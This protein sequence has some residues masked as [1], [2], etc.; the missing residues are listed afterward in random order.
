MLMHMRVGPYCMFTPPPLARYE[1][2]I[3][4]LHL[5]DLAVPLSNLPYVTKGRGISNVLSAAA[6]AA[7]LG[8]LVLGGA[9]SL[10]M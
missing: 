6:L 9:L 1:P 3:P 4:T 8:I 10:N 7:E 2:S 5:L